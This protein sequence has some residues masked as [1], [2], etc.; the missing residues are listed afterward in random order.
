VVKAQGALAELVAMGRD[1]RGAVDHAETLVEALLTMA[2]SERQPVT[3]DLVDLATV[4][5]DVLDGI[6]PADLRVHALLRLATTTG[7]GFGLGLAIVASITTLDHGTVAAHP[8]P[9]GRLKVT[10]TFPA[11]DPPADV[12]A[13]LDPDRTWTST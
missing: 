5:E 9:R 7:D 2:R 13:D 4:A 1:V 6:R 11:A 10:V 8:V 3:R 12:P